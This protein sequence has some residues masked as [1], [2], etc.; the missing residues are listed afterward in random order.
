[1]C[2]ASQTRGLCSAFNIPS[3]PS[4]SLRTFYLS[5]FVCFASQ[6]PGLCSAFNFPSA[7]LPSL[8]TLY[9]SCFV[10]FASQTQ[11]LCSALIALRLPHPGC[12]RFI[13]RFVPFA[14]QTPGLYSVLIFPSVP[15]PSLHT[16]FSVMFVCFPSQTPVFCS[17]SLFS[18]PASHTGLFILSVCFAPK[19]VQYCF[20]RDFF[21]TCAVI[22]FYSEFAVFLLRSPALRLRGAFIPSPA[23]QFCLLC[24]FCLSFTLYNV[25]PAF[26]PRNGFCLVAFRCPS[27]YF[28]VLISSLFT[29][30]FCFSNNGFA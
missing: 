30:V 21:F 5:C 4:P 26:F 20:P 7:P 9:L 1:M 14:S 29:I 6:T 3:A 10:C 27:H 22:G 19:T 12:T 17:A 2:F 11:G 18:S 23:L 13:S 25:F 8:H 28:A 16:F 15:L 24:L